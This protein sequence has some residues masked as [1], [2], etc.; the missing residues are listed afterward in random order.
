MKPSNRTTRAKH[1]ANGLATQPHFPCT[2]CCQ[3]YLLSRLSTHVCL[4]VLMLDKHRLDLCII[5]HALYNTLGSDVKNLPHMLIIKA[6]IIE[7]AILFLQYR[8][9]IV[10]Y[11]QSEIR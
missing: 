9:I 6:H 1:P 5:Y 11:N 4:L 10:C 3:V 8:Q 7:K 2:G